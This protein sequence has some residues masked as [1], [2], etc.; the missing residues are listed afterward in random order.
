[1]L[2]LVRGI[3]GSTAAAI[4][5]VALV[6][7]APASTPDAAP[8]GIPTAASAFT[9]DAIVDG[10]TIETSAGTVRIIGIDAPE[11][12]VCGYTEATALVSSLL[13]PGDPIS[14]ELP[15]GQNEE[16]RYGRLLRYVDTTA[17]V[18]VASSLL[19]AGLAVA[20]YDS[21]DGYPAHP[22]EAAYHAAQL[23]TLAADGAVTTVDCQAAA[24]AEEQARL[25]A[26][27]AAHD[28]AAAPPAAAVDEWWRQY[29]SCT[30]LK[31]NPN[32]HPT[33]PFSRDDPSQAAV[34]DWYA[35]GTGN[36]GD[37]EG[38]GLACE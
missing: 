28:A 27:Q 21:S 36:D 31:K 34:Y 8:S 14:L 12:G 20:R 24:V 32:G 11:R 37:G 2:M 23:A 1:M 33:G 26:E 9:V 16:D 18:D 7:C 30:E 17:G 5:A 25:A 19:S 6:G 3:W 35:N 15:D 13:E 29:S 38:D 10:D 4:V 22:R